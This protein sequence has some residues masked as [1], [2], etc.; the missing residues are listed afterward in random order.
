[1]C[2]VSALFAARHAKLTHRANIDLCFPQWYNL[3][4]MSSTGT[5]TAEEYPS[6]PYIDPVTNDLR[7]PFDCDP[8]YHYW[9]GG[10]SVLKTLEELGAPPEVMHHFNRKDI[11]GRKEE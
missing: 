10:Q 6:K 5:Q 9:K 8:K 2:A 7:S 1:M 11:Y 4:P 3:P